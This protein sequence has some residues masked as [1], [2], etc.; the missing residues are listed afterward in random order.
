MEEGERELEERQYGRG[1]RRVIKGE[2]EQKSDQ[3]NRKG[4]TEVIEGESDF[5]HRKTTK[6]CENPK[7]SFKKYCFNF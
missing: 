5:L 3:V 2:R 7:R 1:L 6:N 4:E